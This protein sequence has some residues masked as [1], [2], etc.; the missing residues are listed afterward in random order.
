MSD[1]NQGQSPMGD[2][3]VL[4]KEKVMRVLTHL[5]GPAAI[6]VVAVNFFMPS[7]NK[8]LGLLVNGVWSLTELGIAAICVTA[9]VTGAIA[10]WPVYKRLIESLA[11][12]ATWAIFEWDPITPMEL[13]IK[14]FVRDGEI[15][16]NTL[17]NV[18]GV[19]SSN[20]HRAQKL[21]DEADRAQG[22]FNAAVKKFGE[23]S[24]EANLAS[25]DVGAPREA[26][27]QIERDTEQLR[28][29]RDVLTEVTQASEFVCKQAEAQVAAVKVQW[30][31]AQETE[32]ATN[33]AFRILRGRSQR[34]LDAQR[35]MEIVR[36]R[37]ASQFGRVRT[38]R[39]LAEKQII[40]VDLEKGVFHAQALLEF[41]NQTALLTG[42]TVQPDVIDVPAIEIKTPVHIG[43]LYGKKK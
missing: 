43:S 25:V 37:F 2:L 5:V 1:L 4:T 13:W 26:A 40:G 12:K 3:P 11:N 7:I 28:V 39:K 19:V 9:V 38:L 32:K 29:L 36:N 30:A 14:E 23:N 17:M 24:H 8:A 10:F 21:R 16:A 33:A 22:R 15:L 27:D 42:K 6:A 20:E 41:K 31:A 18:D 35:S 34:S